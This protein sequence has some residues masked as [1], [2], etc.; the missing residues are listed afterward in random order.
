MNTLCR[1]THCQGSRVIVL[2]FS[3][4]NVWWLANK[5]KEQSEEI[6]SKADVIF[7]SNPSRTVPLWHQKAAKIPGNVVVWV[8][9]YQD[10]CWNPSWL[11]K[12][13]V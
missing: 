7:V 6:V 8:C 4:E 5:L 1:N 9:M 11:S 12:T 3:E 2:L 10:Q 13:L